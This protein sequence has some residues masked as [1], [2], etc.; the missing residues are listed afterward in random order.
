MSLVERLT[1]LVLALAILTVIGSTLGLIGFPL[2]P[3]SVI[4]REPVVQVQV[5]PNGVPVSGS[6]DVSTF[7]D[8]Q[9]TTR[10]GI[11]SNITMTATLADHSQTIQT[12]QTVNDEATF[13]VPSNTVGVRFDAAHSG[14]NGAKTI[15]G[16][17]VISEVYAWGFVSSGLLSGIAFVIGMPK[18]LNKTMLSKKTRRLLFV[19]LP[20]AALVFPTAYLL[21]EEPAWFGTGWAPSSFVGIP[22]YLVS[23]LLVILAVVELLGRLVGR[24]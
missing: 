17:T 23:L 18:W 22:I 6:W 3:L 21:F 7:L 9:N 8:Y 19:V 20:F 4:P 14:S 13:N 15:S 16:P 12:K 1:Q 24:D 11:N 5:M 10:F 2:S